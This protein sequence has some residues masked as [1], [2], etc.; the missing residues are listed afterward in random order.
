MIGFYVVC[1]FAIFPLAILAKPY[2]VFLRNSVI[3]AYQRYKSKN[4]GDVFSVYVKKHYENYTK[5]FS[6]YPDALDFVQDK[7][8]TFFDKSGRITIS[9]WNNVKGISLPICIYQRDIKEG[10]T[11]SFKE[12]KEIIK[13]REIR[14]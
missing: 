8:L 5:L 2:A 1:L 9:H 3:R 12:G 10:K 4:S 7:S 13:I 14:K 11:T 6:N